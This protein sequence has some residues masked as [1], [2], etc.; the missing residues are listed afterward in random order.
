MKNNN[1]P[2]NNSRLLKD[3]KRPA[4]NTKCPVSTIGVTLK[5]ALA[6]ALFGAF[7]YPAYAASDFNFS[8]GAGIEAHDNAA[9]VHRGEESDN[10]RTVSADVG[11]TKDDG[12]LDVDVGYQLTYSD[13]VHD[14]QG[15]ETSINGSTALKWQ[16]LPR[17]FDVVAYH[18]IAQQMT[19]RR[20]LDVE[21]NREERSVVTGG[22]NGYVHLSP[23]DSLIFSP[24]FSDV[25]FQ[26]SDGADSQRATMTLA[27]DHRISNVSK[28]AL[29][30]G[31]DD[32]KF[33]EEENDYTSPSVM[34]SFHTALSRLSYQ[35][36]VGAKRV[37]RDEGDD[38]NGSTATVAIDYAG[39]GQTWG[40]SYIRQ[41]TDTS[42]GLSGMELALNNF[43]S[44]DSNFDVFDIVQENK[45][46]AYWQ[47]RLGASTQISLSAGYRKQDYKNTP[48]DQN[49]AYAGGGLQYAINTRWSARLDTSF[50]R[51]KFIEEPKFEYDT[52]RSSL[53]AIYHPSRPLEIRASI[54]QDKRNA[55]PSTASYTDNIVAVGFRYHFL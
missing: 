25:R 42:V 44:N 27:W 48:R 9:L 10:E 37:K 4:K 47:S 5:P 26:E 2:K 43:T 12:V 13:Y 23:V 24:R 30:A 46:D 33:D 19:D 18:Q 45:A 39:D 3:T 34:L 54:G 40:A 50:E 20:G 15:D 1:C 14:T 52:I 21:S 36:G 16:I 22:F 29:T 38:V 51:T 41:L 6:G 55:D 53:S 17:Q 35:I 31:Y 49:I 32:A 28:L 8:A 11:Y 7:C